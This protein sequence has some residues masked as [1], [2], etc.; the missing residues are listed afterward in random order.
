MKGL[1]QCASFGFFAP[2]GVNGTFI[3]LGWLGCGCAGLWAL[4]CFWS[5]YRVRHRE[6]WSSLAI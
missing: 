2:Q 4:Q 6:P 5:G 3:G 1:L